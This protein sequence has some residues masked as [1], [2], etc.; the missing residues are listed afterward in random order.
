ML[1]STMLMLVVIGAADTAAAAAVTANDDDEDVED[2]I[3]DDGDND[4]DD[5]STYPQESHTKPSP[6]FPE[7]Q[8]PCVCTCRRSAD[9]GGRLHIA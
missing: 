5:G 4:A 1:R 2:D 6:F 9:S 3:D 7:D 8:Q